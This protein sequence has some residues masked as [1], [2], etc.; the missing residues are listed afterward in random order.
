ML[1]KDK[2]SRRSKVKVPL[3]I[4]RV[5]KEFDMSVKDIKSDRRTSE[6]AFAR[7]VAM[8]ILREDFGFKLEQVATYLERKDHTTVLHAVDKI[9]SKL[10]IDEGFKAQMDMLRDNIMNENDL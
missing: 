8:F 5:A 2:K 10:M 3:I 1:G 4:K 6:I 9:K 7:Q